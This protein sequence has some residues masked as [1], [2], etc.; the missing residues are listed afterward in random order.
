MINRIIA[1]TFKIQHEIGKGSF[2]SIYQ[3]QH[4]KSKKEVAIKV[5]KKN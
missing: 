4:L 5:E 3:A 2:G 1:N